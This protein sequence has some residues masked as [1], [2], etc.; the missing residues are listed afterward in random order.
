MVKKEKKMDEELI[1][2]PSERL[3]KMRQEIIDLLIECKWDLVEEKYG[4]A[5][6]RN[7]KIKKLFD[8]YLVDFVVNPL[9]Q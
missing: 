9:S 3:R 1:F 2:E 4:E 6:E 8:E 5:I 7:E